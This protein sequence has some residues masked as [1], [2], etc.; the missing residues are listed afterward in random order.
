VVC[1][2][3]KFAADDIVSGTLAEAR[4]PKRTLIHGE[5]RVAPRADGMMLRRAPVAQLDRA[6][7]FES[8][9]RRFESCRARQPFAYDVP[10]AGFGLGRPSNDR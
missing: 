2:R 8:V 9:G 6:P 7:D 1:L 5:R 3:A 4:R 10:D